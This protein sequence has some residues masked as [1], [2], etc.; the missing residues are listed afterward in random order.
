MEINGGIISSRT[1]LF[2]LKEDVT[3][4]NVTSRSKAV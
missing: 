3:E 1:M 4:V 2:V